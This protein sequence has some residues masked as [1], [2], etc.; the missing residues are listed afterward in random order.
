MKVRDHYRRTAENP[1]I[2]AILRIIYSTV[3]QAVL[4]FT[5]L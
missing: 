1:L 5:C 3:D 2:F 4:T